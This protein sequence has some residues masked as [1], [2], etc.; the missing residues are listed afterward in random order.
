MV[1]ERLDQEL[2]QRE[3]LHPFTSPTSLRSVS[4]THL[5]AFILSFHLQPFPSLYP[6]IH[7]L[8]ISEAGDG[9]EKRDEADRRNRRTSQSFPFPAVLSPRLNSEVKEGQR[10]VDGLVCVG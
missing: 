5:A 4:L 3:Q 7:L 1:S 8:L 10:D 9:K 6:F 2:G